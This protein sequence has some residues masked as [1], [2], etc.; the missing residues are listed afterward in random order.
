LKLIPIIGV[1]GSELFMKKIFI[2]Y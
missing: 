1:I 2:L